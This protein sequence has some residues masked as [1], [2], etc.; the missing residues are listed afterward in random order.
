MT[1]ALSHRKHGADNHLYGAGAQGW[2]V[3]ASVTEH[4][5][6]VRV[7]AECKYTALTEGDAVKFHD[8]LYAAVVEVIRQGAELRHINIPLFNLPTSDTTEGINTR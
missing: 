6:K 4:G 2:A 5:W 1:P 8:M 7:S 3:K